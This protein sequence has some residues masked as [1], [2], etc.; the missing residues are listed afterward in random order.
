[1]D[2][3]T[4]LTLSFLRADFRARMQTK[5]ARFKLADDGARFLPGQP[6][7]TPRIGRAEAV[8]I[9]RSWEEQA[10]V[11]NADSLQGK[12]GGGTE[13]ERP[14]P[15]GLPVAAGSDQPAPRHRREHQ[16]HPVGD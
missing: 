11:E 2:V 15:A 14:E 1:M 16:L 7:I 3:N 10:L 13:P 8:A 9:F 5:Y 12:S 4:P 6:V